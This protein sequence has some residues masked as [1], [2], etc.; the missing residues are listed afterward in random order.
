MKKLVKRMVL[1]SAYGMSIKPLSA[2]VETRDPEN[3]LLHRMNLRRLEAEAI[4]DAILSVSGRLTES[5]Y[6]VSVPLHESQFVEARGLRSERGPLDGN[7]RRSLY[8]SARRNF[9]PM[10]MT[11]FD[12]PI[13]FT[14]VGRRN[15]S[16]VPGQMLFLMNDPFVH[17]Q[18][19]VWAQRNEREGSQTS[20]DAR[21]Q[22]LF[23]AAFS[24]PSTTKELASCR[25]TLRVAR[26]LAEAGSSTT[27]E[28]TELCHALFGA[29][30]FIF[31]Q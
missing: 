31:I 15:L 9:L 11:A 27:D 25:E 28:W 24:R 21:I 10:M 12:M 26:G 17:Q 8:V 1:S 16:N 2:E 23:L 7:G 3:V 19:E 20:E 30:E 29:K 22:K 14:T 5:M 4:R 13:P 18:A 6:G